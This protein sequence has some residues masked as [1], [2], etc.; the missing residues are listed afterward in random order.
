MHYNNG[1]QI[2]GAD[3]RRG[4]RPGGVLRWPMGPARIDPPSYDANFIV[5]NKPTFATCC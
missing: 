2:I 5:K 4:D 1:K 3:A